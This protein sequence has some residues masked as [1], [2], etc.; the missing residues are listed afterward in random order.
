MNSSLP[1]HAE[2]DLPIACTLTFF[3][4]FD[5]ETYVIRYVFVRNQ[6]FH[7]HTFK[8]T[9]D[10]H[11]LVLTDARAINVVTQHGAIRVA[12]TLQRTVLPIETLKAFIVASNS[13]VAWLTVALPSYGAAFR[14]VTAF[15]NP[16]TSVTIQ[17]SRTSWEGQES[18]N[19]YAVQYYICIT[20]KKLQQ[21]N[22]IH[23]ALHPAMNMPLIFK[24]KAGT[25]NINQCD[26][27]QRRLHPVQ[28]SCTLVVSEQ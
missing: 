15:T 5:Y 2:M 6:L 27:L 8:F 24:L 18:C 17:T 22:C 3:M 10:T 9:L 13:T 11:P 23:Y 21:Q 28:N 14:D 20:D 25:E 7:V 1:N 16:T 4:H 12:A 26:T 19:K